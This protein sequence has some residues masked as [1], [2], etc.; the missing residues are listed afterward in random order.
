MAADYEYHAASAEMIFR[1]AIGQKS[2]PADLPG[3]VIALAIDPDYGPALLTVGTHEYILGRCEEAERILLSLLNLA[4]D[5]EDLLII[6]HKAGRFLLDRGDYSR[7]LTLY[8]KAAKSYPDELMFQAG[9]ADCS[10]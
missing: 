5:T 7:A 9:I 2:P 6:L 4:E 10:Q 1:D 3:E 8:T